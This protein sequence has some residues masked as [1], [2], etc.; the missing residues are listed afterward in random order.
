MSDNRNR[1]SRLQEVALQAGVSP[2]TVSR[3]LRTPTMVSPATRARVEAAIK[4]TDYIPNAIARGLA[5]NRTKLVAAIFPNLQNQLFTDTI[6]G[7]SQVLEDNGLSLV[8]GSVGRAAESEQTLIASILTYRP[9]AVF[10]HR[11]VHTERSRRMLRDPGLVLIEGGNLVA[12]PID[13]VVSYSHQAAAQ[14]LTAVLLARGRTSLAFVG[15]IESS[16]HEAHFAGYRAALEASGKSSSGQ[17]PIHVP[18]SYE[19]GRAIVRELTAAGSPL[20]DGIV[21]ASATSAAGALV[22]CRRAGIAVPERLSLVSLDNSD[23]APNLFPPLTAVQLSRVG[24]WAMCRQDHRRS[25]GRSHGASQRKARLHHR[26]A[27]EPL[28]GRRSGRTRLRQRQTV[29]KGRNCRILPTV[30]SVFTI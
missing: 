24:T 11:T 20:V 6:F 17:R 13:A 28:I 14:A 30:S 7:L 1:P 9:C 8:V 12:D 10:L 19:S 2:I 5:S 18:H 29:N 23:L 3:V 21:F 27:R 16:R 25:F 26:T 15:S 4:A 22:E